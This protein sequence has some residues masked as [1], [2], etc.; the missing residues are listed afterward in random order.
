MPSLYFEDKLQKERIMDNDDWA[1]I[2]DNASNALELSPNDTVL[3]FNRAFAYFNM[4]DFEKA[5]ED[6]NK[7]IELSPE[8]AEAYFR[9]AN[10]FL[11]LD[12]I[13]EAVS[14][15]ETFLELDPDNANAEA[16]KEALETLKA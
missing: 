1:E 12:N 3:Y 9:R 4:G 5:L 11:Q 14:D 2:A 10:I 8:D 6:Y 16:V 15:F 13:Q 7:A